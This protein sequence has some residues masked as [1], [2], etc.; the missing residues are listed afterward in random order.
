MSEEKLYACWSRSLSSAAVAPVPMPCAANAKSASWY[1]S[2][3]MHQVMKL[4]SAGG[5]LPSPPVST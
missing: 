2:P 5:T 1:G 3:G 4:D